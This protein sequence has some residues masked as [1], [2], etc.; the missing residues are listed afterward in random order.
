MISLDPDGVG[1]GIGHTINEGILISVQWI[2][3]RSAVGQSGGC[4]WIRG[5]IKP[6]Q[7]R[8]RRI[9]KNILVSKPLVNRT[10]KRAKGGYGAAA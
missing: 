2:E 6:L 10:L 8:C 7:E 1:S 5:R 9:T 4:S 3:L